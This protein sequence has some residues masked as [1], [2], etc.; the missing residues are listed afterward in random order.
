MTIAET[1]VGWIVKVVGFVVI[2][3]FILTL[4]ED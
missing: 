1:I 4:R 3:T 2:M